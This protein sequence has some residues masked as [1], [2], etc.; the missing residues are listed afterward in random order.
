M[1]EKDM[2]KIQTQEISIFFI[3]DKNGRRIFKI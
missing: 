3:C 2:D 1:F